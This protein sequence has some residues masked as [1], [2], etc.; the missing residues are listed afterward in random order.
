MA[1]NVKA[2]KKEKEAPTLMG[3]E[4]DLATEISKQSAEIQALITSKGIVADITVVKK[5]IDGKPYTKQYLRL[6]P[7][8]APAML[9]LA[10]GVESTWKEEVDKDGNDISDFDGPCMVKDFYYGNDLAVKNKEGQA[11]SVLVEGPDKAKLAAAKQLAKAWGITPE[12]AL[13]KIERMAESE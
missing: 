6:K 7:T 12:D 4:L 2:E 1:K 5:D 9:V 11:L 3:G 8:A 13:K 10:K